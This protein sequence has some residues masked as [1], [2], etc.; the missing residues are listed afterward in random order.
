MPREGHWLMLVGKSS[1]SGLP[2]YRMEPMLFYGLDEIRRFSAPRSLLRS[3]GA[4][5]QET[6]LPRWARR[7]DDGSK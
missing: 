2:L 5:E 1:G 6:T 3:C 4:P 7:L